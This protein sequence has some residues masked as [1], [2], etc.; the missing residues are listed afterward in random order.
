MIY[1][2]LDEMLDNGF[3]LATE[4]NI[5]KE[6]IKPPNILRTVVN[7]V[8]GKTNMS[9]T[10]PTGQV[11]TST[12]HLNGDKIESNLIVPGIQECKRIPS[13]RASKS[14]G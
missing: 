10:L 8:T 2:L 5:L 12:T 11:L 14:L 13:S 4:S 6:L 1:E 3:P 9:E 7:T